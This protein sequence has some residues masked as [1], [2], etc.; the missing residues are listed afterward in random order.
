MLVYE[1]KFVR[2]FFCVKL[3]LEEKNSEKMFGRKT[4][5]L[6]NFAIKKFG[7]AKKEEKKLG[8]K[9]VW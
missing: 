9:N 4:F 8:Q 1:K 6:E 2:K 3:W 5:W 7:P